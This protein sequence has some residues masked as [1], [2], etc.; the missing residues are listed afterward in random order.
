M[1]S[2][3][4]PKDSEV[5]A[6]D[7]IYHL[8]LLASALQTSSRTNEGDKH[9][10]NTQQGRA[11]NHLSVCLSRGTESEIAV[12]ASSWS[13]EDVRLSVFISPRATPTSSLNISRSSSGVVQV[14]DSEKAEEGNTI[15]SLNSD[16]RHPHGSVHEAVIEAHN[17]ADS[18]P[19]LDTIMGLDIDC[20]E[21]DIHPKDS[22]ED[23]V[24]ESLKILR[25]AAVRV[26]HSTPETAAEI[27]EA[28]CL[29]FLSAC[30][31]KV[32]RRIHTLTRAY[33]LPKLWKWEPTAADLNTPD[34][35]VN[36]V[37][38]GLQ[39][40]LG[41]SGVASEGHVFH[42]NGGNVLCWWQALLKFL[43]IFCKI[44]ATRPGPLKLL[45]TASTT[46]HQLVT[47]IP[48]QLWA[49]K[50]LGYHLQSCLKGTAASTGE[51]ENDRDDDV[52]VVSDVLRS[53]PKYLVHSR[54]SRSSSRLHLA[55][56]NLPR[57]PINNV[58]SSKLIK[59]WGA[60]CSWSEETKADLTSLVEVEKIQEQDVD[61][62]RGACHCEAGLMASL[63]A[64]L[65][66]KGPNDE[67]GVQ[68][69]VLS[70][71]FAKMDM[72]ASQ[73]SIGMAKKCCPVCRLLAETIK[74]AHGLDLE[75]PGKHLHYYPWVPPHW[76]PASI[77][78][79]MDRR[80]IGIIDEMVTADRHL[81][82]SRT[83]S[84]ASD[85]S[86]EKKKSMMYVSD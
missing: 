72:Q 40:I 58:E 54:I 30:L 27:E 52:E 80:L 12:T 25:A 18:F 59:R 24:P 7:S 49:M 76:L 2:P 74:S 13:Y 86:V 15:L 3:E 77:L 9:A 17:H 56:I 23:F 32:Q 28:V 50:S 53:G 71:V 81:D 67:V 11:L 38:P 69:E 62:V 36:I 85:R 29:Y 47:H 26:A 75:L 51:G 35:T 66:L 37:D 14:I 19:P 63:I 79:A 82:T 57:K 22:L 45:C 4:V 31:P 55:L 60:L 46:L 20:T 48:R 6:R 41:K 44:L 21:D 42:F 33:D 83:S 84:P 5:T 70:N 39:S 10:N 61:R 1:P 16:P 73:F 78:E 34:S 43:N 64:H 65:E 8:T 68:P